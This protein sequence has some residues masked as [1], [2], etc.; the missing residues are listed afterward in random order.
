MMISPGVLRFLTPLKMVH[1][2][3][4]VLLVHPDL[5]LSIDH[6]DAPL[7]E[8]QLTACFH[9]QLELLFQEGLDLL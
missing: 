9:C 6:F 1:Q 7:Q 2:S 3:F 4:D 5:R 8:I